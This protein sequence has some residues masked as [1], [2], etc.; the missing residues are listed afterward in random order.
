[1]TT[2]F[3]DVCQE[4]DE[5]LAKQ[6]VAGAEFDEVIYA[7][8]TICISTGTEAINKFLGAIG[9]EGFRYGLK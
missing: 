2:M 9:W 1:M 6:T 3:Y 7:V 5:Y 8:D 4:T